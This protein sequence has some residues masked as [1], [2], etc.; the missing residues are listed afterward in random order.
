MDWGLLTFARD[1]RVYRRQRVLLPIPFYAIAVIVNL[2]LRFSWTVNRIPGLEHIHSSIIILFIEI[3]EVVRRSM[4]NIFRIEWE[5][6]V[7]S[8]K[9][10]DKLPAANDKR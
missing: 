2:L 3:G 6:I 4:W 5:V 7:Q 10:L 1:G 9:S 8:D